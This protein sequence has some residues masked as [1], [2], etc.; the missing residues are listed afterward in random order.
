M[1]L[2]PAGTCT[3]DQDRNSVKGFST[4]T[5]RTTSLIPSSVSLTYSTT[6]AAGENSF[7]LCASVTHAFDFDANK[8]STFRFRNL[9]GTFVSTSTP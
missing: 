9:V 5:F 3:Y 2:Q 7:D 4:T 1:W 8:R 6:V